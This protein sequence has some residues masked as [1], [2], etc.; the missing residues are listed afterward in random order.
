MGRQLPHVVEQTW[1]IGDGFES[2]ARV[3][4]GVI[5]SRNDAAGF[6]FGRIPRRTDVGGWPLKDGEGFYFGYGVPPLRIGF[7]DVPAEGAV[8][9]GLGVEDHRDVTREES[10]LAQSDKG[11]EGVLRDEVVEGFDA[12]FAKVGRVIHYRFKPSTSFMDPCR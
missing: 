9:L 8:R 4:D 11:R 5:V 6:S 1:V 3:N 7:G 12:V 10:V 2:A